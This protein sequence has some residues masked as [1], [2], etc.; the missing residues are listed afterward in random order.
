M[1]NYNVPE[2]EQEKDTICCGWQ[3]KALRCSKMFLSINGNLHR[4]RKNLLGQVSIPE[5]RQN[6]ICPLKFH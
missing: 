3:N 5:G 4:D 6:T 2:E 1:A